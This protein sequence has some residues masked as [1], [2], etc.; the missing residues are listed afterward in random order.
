M[1][2]EGIWVKIFGNKDVVKVVLGIALHPTDLLEN[3][4]TKYLET[5]RMEL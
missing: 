2:S 1:M 4:C 3:L 5:L